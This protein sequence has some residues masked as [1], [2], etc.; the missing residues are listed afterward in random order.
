MANLL[1]WNEHTFV[2]GNGILTGCDQRQEWMLKWWWKNYSQSNDTPVTLFDFGMTPCA[3]KWCES[4]FQ[5]IPFSLPSSFI[6]PISQA[7]KWPSKTARYVWNVR[8]IWFSKALCLPQTPYEKNIWIDL[9]CQVKKKISS[10]FSFCQSGDGF[11]IALDTPS[12][13]LDFRKNDCLSEE[14]QG[15]QT[16]VFAFKRKSPVVNAWLKACYDQRDQEF[17]EQS[18]LCH[19]LHRTDFDFVH[20]SN[21][22]NWLFPEDKNSRALIVHHTGASHKRQL[23]LEVALC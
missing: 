4:R 8:P 1:K 13:I 22:Y 23:M 5:V 14:A 20:I 15:Y 10:L 6:T 12:N 9:D 3:R 17:S 11:A 21:H 7:V 16:G 18:T 19:T 2:G